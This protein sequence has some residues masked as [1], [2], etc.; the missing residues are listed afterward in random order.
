LP[1][2][3]YVFWNNAGEWRTPRA[4]A[5]ARYYRLHLNRLTVV[6]F[7][8]SSSTQ[9]TSVQCRYFT[10]NFKGPGGKMII[11]WKQQNVMNHR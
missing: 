7:V 6:A 8:Q 3:S 11:R 5:H 10:S 9:T 4:R 2:V 1:Y